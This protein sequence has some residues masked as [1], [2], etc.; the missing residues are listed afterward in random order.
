M[1]TSHISRTNNLYRKKMKRYKGDA[2]DM[3]IDGH[4]GVDWD[5]LDQEGL[6]YDR[7]Y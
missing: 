7:E 5:E 2:A 4:L 3:L 6:Y 1:W